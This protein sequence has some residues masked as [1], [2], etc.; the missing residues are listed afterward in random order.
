MLRVVSFL[1]GAIGG[2]A[3]VLVGLN[4]NAIQPFMGDREPDPRAAHEREQRQHQH[5][6][7]GEDQDLGRADP[8]VAT[9]LLTR[10]RKAKAPEL[11][12]LMVTLGAT[13]F[14]YAGMA[15]VGRP[16]PCV[17]QSAAKA[18]SAK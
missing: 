5:D 11:S 18:P 12:S 10:L 17:L 15:A 2:A 4:F 7:G 3:G 1:S 14:L 16:S 8:H 9:L 6:G 13:L